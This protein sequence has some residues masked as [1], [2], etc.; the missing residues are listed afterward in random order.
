MQKIICGVDLGGTKIKTGLVDEKGKIISSI[1]IP[2]LAQEGPDAVIK[3]IVRSI[4]DVSNMANIAISNISGIGIG[5]PGQLDVPKGLIVNMPN[6]PGWNNIPLAERISKELKLPV[7]ID[8]DANAAA[9]GEYL[10]GVGNGIDIFMYI[11]ISTGI[12]GG[13]IINGEIYHGA[14]SNALEIGHMTIDF[15]GPKCNCGNYGCF[16][17][18]ASGTALAR[19][20]N[21]LL[22]SEK[23]TLLKDITNTD[24]IKAEHVFK[25]AQLGDKLS[26]DLIDKESFYLGIG[27]SNLIT[28]F[29]PRR[30]AIGGGMSN[31]LDVMY[32]K[33]VETINTRALKAN[34]SICDIVKAKLGDNTGLLGAVSLML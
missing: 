17:S 10:F 26:K 11:T 7:K 3:R 30:I 28:L 2:T 9:L 33:I 27:I 23:N 19:Y 8:N 6:L 1:K 31:D 32:D 5:V 21:D 18:M 16:E 14:N 12:G 24:E 34:A 13:L 20:A 29:N 4:T 22:T 25:A 15:N